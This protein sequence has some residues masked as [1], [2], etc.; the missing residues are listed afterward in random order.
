MTDSAAE[1]TERRS[2]ARYLLEGRRVRLADLLASGLIKDGEQLTFVRPLVGETHHA[3]VTSKGWIRLDNGEEFRSPSKAASAAVGSGSYDGWN[4]WAVSDHRLLAALRQQLLDQAAAEDGPGAVEGPRTAVS[5]SE[6]HA[7]LKRARE[8]AEA[9][10]PQSLTVQELLAWWGATVRGLVNDQIQA[11]LANHSLTTSPGFDTVPL[12]TGIQMLTTVDDEAAEERTPDTG[13]SDD[14]SDGSKESRE[15]GLT[16]GTLPSVLGNDLVSVKSTAT[17]EQAITLMVLHDFS[18]LPVIDNPHRPPGAV[19]WKSIARARH[20]NV[21]AS[22]AQAIFAPREVR[23][24]HDLIDVIPALE[25]LDFV[26]VR[27]QHGRTAGIVTA[28]DIAQAYG[29]MAS[30]FFVIGELDRRL[31]RI[32]AGTFTLTEVTDLC[33]PKGARITSFDDMTIGDYKRVLEN[34]SRWQQLGWPLDRKIFIE[35]LDEI[36]KIRNNVMHFNSNDALPPSDVDK[37]RNLNK[38]LREYGE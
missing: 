18:Q 26:L 9:G 11:E 35:R 20:A 28:A 16:V 29:E 7:R 34:P 17:F 38:L 32:I 22:F 36:R 5:P 25:E 31:R 15:V 6:R 14:T 2:R 10:Q 13:V 21:D 1:P 8:L 12:S 24:D 4:A 23:Y 27:D 19:S 3:T 33:D 30:H 37:I